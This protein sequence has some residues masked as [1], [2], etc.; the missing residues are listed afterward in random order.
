MAIHT[1]KQTKQ[2]IDWFEDRE[3]EVIDT[4]YGNDLC[5]SIEVNSLHVFLPNSFIHSPVEEKYKSFTVKVDENNYE[6]F[7]DIEEVF[8]FLTKK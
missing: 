8:N 2:I 4:S 1:P 6:E 5:D 3:L 7:F